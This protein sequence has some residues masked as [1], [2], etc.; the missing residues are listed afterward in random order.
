[1]AHLQNLCGEKLLL[2]QREGSVQRVRGVLHKAPV[3]FMGQTPAGDPRVKGVAERAVEIDKGGKTGQVQA[4]QATHLY[5]QG[6]GLRRHARTQQ[7]RQLCGVHG[8]CGVLVLLRQR[9]PAPWLLSLTPL[10]RPQHLFC[11]GKA[12]VRGLFQGLGNHGLQVWRYL[13]VRVHLGHWQ[14]RLVHV[15]EEHLHGRLSPKGKGARQHA[16]EDNTQGVQVGASIEGVTLNLLR[17]HE[18]RGAQ[19]GFWFGHLGRLTDLVDDPEIEDFHEVPQEIIWGDEQV[20]GL[21]VPVNQALAVGFHQPGADLLGDG[22]GPGWRKGSGL[23][24]HLTQALALEVLHDD[25][26]AGLR[27]LAVVEHPDDVGLAEPSA[28]G[29]LQEEPPTEFRVGVALGQEQLDRHHAVQGQLPGLEDPA[30]PPL[31]DELH[32]LVPALQD[33]ADQRLVG[34]NL[35]GNKHSLVQGGNRQSL[36]S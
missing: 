26:I 12:L 22:D 10:K 13:A 29:G 3:D 8:L 32:Q 34:V 20:G 18:Q 17:G 9:R 11:R 21:E 33:P 28:E 24:E 4:H 23:C 35:H 27:V 16:V 6:A 2:V 19:G 30:H 25:I 14:R 15:L 31:C 5:R 1:M 7:S 36:L